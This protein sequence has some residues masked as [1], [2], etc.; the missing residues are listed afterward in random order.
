MMSHFHQHFHSSEQTPE[1][2]GNVIHWAASYDVLTNRIL[3]PSEASIGALAGIKPGTKVLDVG[4]GSGRLT[5]AAQ[6]W[7]GP[8]GEAQGIDPAP[9]AIKV[10]R[11][12]A[13]RAGL[14][15]KF[16]VG[17]VE[18]IPF[19]DA[20]FDVVLSRLVLHHLPGDFICSKPLFG[21]LSSDQQP[22]R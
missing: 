10:A 4:C 2:R 8:T 5:M 3:R 13:A 21:E 11:E 15:A 14:A 7:V 1:T 22:V 12:N 19:P 20:T 9:E 18:A 6:K 17:L 16:D